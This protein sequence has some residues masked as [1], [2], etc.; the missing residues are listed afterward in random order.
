MW[1][2]DKATI[3]VAGLRGNHGF[4]LGRVVNRCRCWLEQEGDPGGGR[5]PASV[6]PDVAALRPSELLESFSEVNSRRRI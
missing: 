1:H 2:N 5:R 6:D 3:R 4:E